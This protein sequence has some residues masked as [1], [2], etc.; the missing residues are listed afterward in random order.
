MGCPSPYRPDWNPS[1][2][3]REAFWAYRPNAETPLPIVPSVLVARP[4]ELA[5]SKTELPAMVL[6]RDNT[7]TPPKPYF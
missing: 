4:V 7:R 1:W 5:I 6:H 2:G 3:N